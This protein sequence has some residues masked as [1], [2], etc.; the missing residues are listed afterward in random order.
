VEQAAARWSRE[1]PFY[2]IAMIFRSAMSA[3]IASFRC[4]AIY[5]GYRGIADLAKHPPGRFMKPTPYAEA[6][7]GAACA[8]AFALGNGLKVIAIRN[9]PSPMAQEPT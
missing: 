9:A 3:H 5:V 6:G 4:H 7:T 1:A 8:L 2:P